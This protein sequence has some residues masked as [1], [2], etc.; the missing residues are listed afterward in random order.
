MAAAPTEQ[1]ARHPGGRPWLLLV[2]AGLVGLSGLALAAGGFLLV[3]LGGSAYYLIAGAVMLACAV[4][5]ALRSPL[6]PMLYALLVLGTLAWAVWE[7]GLDWWQLVPRGDVVFVFGLLL[8]LPWA[9]RRLT[10]ASRIPLRIAVLALAG[11]LVVAAAVGFAALLTPDGNEWN[12]GLAAHDVSPPALLAA[13]AGDWPAYGGTWA[14]QKFSPLVQ[15]DTGNVGR[16]ERAWTFHTG[17]HPRPGDPN[18]F[19]N[20]V[21][22]IKVADTLYFCTPHDIVY[23][24]DPET[25]AVRWKFD[26]QIRVSPNL[27]HLTCRGVSYA[28]VAGTDCP[29]RLFLA[30]N[31]ARLIA[32]DPRTGKLCGGFG[33]G[34]QLDLW[35]GMPHLQ[36]GWYQITS[37]PLVTRG[38]VVLAGAIYD[39]AAV[40]MP[41]GAIR[42][43]DAASG[44]LVWNF[45]PGNP[46]R[47]APIA[48]GQSYLP[49]TPNSWSTSAADDALGLI[50]VPMG[51]GAIDQWGG[52]RSPMTERYT[53][54]ILALDA[55]TGKERWHFQTVHHDLWDMDVPAQPALV[56]LDIP[57]KGRV[58]AL[59]QST[60]TGNVFV[61]DRRTGAPLLPVVERPVPGGPA[62]GDHLSSTQPF[63]AASFF[64]QAPIRERDMWGVTPFDQL[65]CR[66]GF[67]HLRYDGP[68][69]PPSLQGTI[70]FPGNFGVMDWGG[71]A[72]DPIHQVAFA[73]P[74]YMAFVDKLVPQAKIKR[75]T[76]GPS[77]GSDLAGQERG[78][79]PNRGAPFAVLL[80]P[81]LSEIGLPCQAP[82]WG[83]VAGLDLTTGKVAW[84]RINGTI[85]DESPVPLPIAMG[86]PSLGGPLATR[87]GIAFL[88]S[89]LDYYLRA[90]DMR[91]GK[92]LWR[93]RLPAGGQAS[94]MSYLSAASGR[95]FVVVMAGGHRSLGTSLGD[96]LVAY[97]LPRPKT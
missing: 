3:T 73:H 71:M 45:D 17:D 27:Q 50:Y 11:S 61:L 28:R 5:L 77:G 47:T 2:L 91:T 57:G 54:T 24:L 23:A 16:L 14:G 32:L 79:N 80:N 30:T 95:Q 62:P 81:F 8:C 90:Y 53:A 10:R 37:A 9:F 34:G 42:A 72:I 35:A 22:P 7:V 4:L 1:A 97:A 25:G 38:K 18:E 59:V 64:P 67:R 20:E 76:K 86:V 63:S 26:P 55:D 82:P 49:S 31:D 19:T 48:P 51:N 74:N 29:E 65:A 75:G 96:E 52:N 84:R 88:A 60:K 58:P 36:D 89:T 83:Y 93:S 94:P 66:L 6:A 70:V 40:T 12:H 46:T 44:R 13:Q 69:T 41:S 21:T 15:I 33:N 78:L 85:R 56:D 87:G 39:N 43:F 68:F 92:L